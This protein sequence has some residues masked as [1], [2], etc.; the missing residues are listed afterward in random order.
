L[1]DI[2]YTVLLPHGDSSRYDLVIED[3]DGKF[4]RIQC[5]TAFREKGNDGSICFSVASLKSR[6]SGGK[7]SY[8]RRGYAGEVDYFAVYCHEL[9]KVYLIPIQDANQATRMFLR[10][11]RST[12][13]NQTRGVHFAEDYEI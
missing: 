1:L 2:G 10:L 6:Q 5:K 11:D 9:R 13:N 7:I 3:E 8:G 12:K 4:W